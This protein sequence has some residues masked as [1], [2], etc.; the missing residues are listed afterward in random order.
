MRSARH[1]SYVIWKRPFF[2]TFIGGGAVRVV[3]KPPECKLSNN[4]VKN[5]VGYAW[6]HISDGRKLLKFRRN[7]R[8]LHAVQVRFRIPRRGPRDVPSSKSSNRGTGGGWGGSPSFC[9]ITTRENRVSLL[10][11]VTAASYCYYYYSTLSLVWF[12][13]IHFRVFVRVTKRQTASDV[14]ADR[15]RAWSLAV[16]TR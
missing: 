12:E 13:L 10:G 11:D 1:N 8:K 15:T 16:G 2:K 7:R 5:G 4:T 3:R 14:V 9:T 6:R